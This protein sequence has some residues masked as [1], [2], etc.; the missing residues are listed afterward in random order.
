[1]SQQRR[2]NNRHNDDVITIDDETEDLQDN[3]GLHLPDPMRSS[4]HISNPMFFISIAFTNGDDIVWG[5]YYVINSEV[6][7]N[8][9]HTTNIYPDP[10]NEAHEDRCVVI[11]ASKK[12]PRDIWHE[13]FHKLVSRDCMDQLYG[14]MTLR[15]DL[16]ESIQ[17]HN[18]YQPSPSRLSLPRMRTSRNGPFML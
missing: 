7:T 18:S 14:V 16:Y 3:S 15:H 1:M 10:Y 6:Y 9:M 17:H 2:D 13:D 12:L 11:F 8:T 5:I 4:I